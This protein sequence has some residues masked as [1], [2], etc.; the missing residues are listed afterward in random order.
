MVQNVRPALNIGCLCL[1][2]SNIVS[3]SMDHRNTEFRNCCLEKKGNFSLT[4]LE[5]QNTQTGTDWDL[6]KMFLKRCIS[7][8]EQAR[9]SVLTSAGEETGHWLE[10]RLPH[11]DR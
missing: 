3:V 4:C 7:F 9:F 5:Q 2:V 6:P 1:C 10:D 11:T 8:T